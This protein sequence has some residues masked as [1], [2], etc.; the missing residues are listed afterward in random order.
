MEIIKAIKTILVIVGFIA[1]II[2]FAN[3]STALLMEYQKENR[4]PAYFNGW[5]VFIC[6]IITFIF[7]L[8]LTSLTFQNI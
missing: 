1:W 5:I 2:Y 4:S 6:G 7:V 3:A 8:I